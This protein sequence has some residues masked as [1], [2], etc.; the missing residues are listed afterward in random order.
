MTKL[1]ELSKLGQSIWLDYIQRSL[2]TSGKLQ[3]LIDQGLRGMTSNPTIFE[4]AIN[5]SSDY[6]EAIKKLASE[7]KSAYEIYESLAFEDISLAAD[8]FRKVYESTE[9]LDGYVSLEANPKLANDTERTIEEVRYLFK[10]L[11]RPNV[12]IK[13][14]ATPAGIPAI[15]TLIS[16]G[17]NVNVTLIFSLS[18]YEDVAK[19]YINGLEKFAQNGGDVK[20]VASVASFFVSRIDTSVDKQLQEIGNTDLQ[21]KIAI[22]CSRVVYGK[23]KEIFQGDKWEQLSSIGARLQRPLWGSTS[24]KNPNYPDT[25]YVDN[26]IAPNTVNTLPLNVIEAFLDHG[27]VE[28]SIEQHIEE[29]HELLNKLKQLGIDLDKITNELML[30]GVQAFIE[31]FDKL[32]N[33]IDEK[34]K[35][36]R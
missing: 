15:E 25:M 26:L 32:I 22:A 5:G 19:A 8:V 12:M 10:T 33:S 14:P 21:G 35:A 1:H 16:E 27:K 3:E 13:V 9:G 18:Q 24:T 17:I 23:F 31:S 20:K 2:I 7:G 34:S 28:K 30:N 11:N 36:L 4:R 6:D 29:S